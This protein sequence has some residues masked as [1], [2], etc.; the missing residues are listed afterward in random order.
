MKQ[1][2][3]YSDVFLQFPALWPSSPEWNW[4][5][6]HDGVSPDLSK[7][8]EL[9][10]QYIKSDDVVVIIHSDVGVAKKLSKHN[11]VDFFL[12]YILQ[13]DIQVS[14][15]NYSCFLSISRYG[16]ATGDA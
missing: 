16:V 7:L 4:V 12:G 2:K 3:L 15:Q 1:S 8:N 11:A 13:Y 14:D 9:I 6:V 5:S 10:E